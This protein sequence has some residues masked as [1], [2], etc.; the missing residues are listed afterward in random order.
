L[1]L[2]YIRLLES[3]KILIKR[4]LLLLMLFELINW[5]IDDL[6]KISHISAEIFENFNLRELME[7]FLRFAILIHGF[8]NLP[9]K[10]LKIILLIYYVPILAFTQQTIK[11][12]YLL[13]K[14]LLMK[15][16]ILM[17]F[18]LGLNEHVGCKLL[19]PSHHDLW[20]YSKVILFF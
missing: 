20:F 1:A 11:V 6:K 16:N 12:V 3:L 4:L 17:H 18:S 5:K 9:F 13:F 7:S 14:P 2:A 15:V 10:K 19:Y 8:I